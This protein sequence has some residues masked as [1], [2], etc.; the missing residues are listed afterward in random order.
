MRIRVPILLA[1]AAIAAAAF[2]QIEGSDRGVVPVASTSSYEVNGVT[3]DVAAKTPDEARYGG[4]RSAQR[5]AW[6][7]L[8]KR[9]GG[10]GGAVGDATLDQLVSG[11]VVEH[12]QIGPTRYIA[13]LGVLFNRAR[14]AALLGIVDQAA[15]SAPMLVIPIE[16]SG[17]VAQA[18]ERRTEWQAAW[19]RYRTGNS[20]IDYV[21]VAGT[22]P[23]SLLL[24]YGQ[25]QRRG[26]TWWRRLLDQY[27]ASDI[28]VPSVRLT[29]Q[30][31][32]GPVIGVFQ[33]R[34]GPDG[35]LLDSFTLRVNSSDGIPQ[36]L[37]AGVKR[38]DELYGRA[39]SAGALSTDPALRPPPQP[40]PVPTDEVGDL[41]EESDTVEET[42]TPTLAGQGVAVT[43]QYDSPTA[44][45][46]A[47]TESSLRGV[48]GVRSASTTSLALGGVSLMRVAFDGDPAALRA[49]LE[50]R[51]F[52]V[53]GSGTTLRIRRA[54]QLLPPDIPPDSAPSE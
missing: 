31:P 16:H 25:T 47:N 4:W 32:G 20:A 41:I 13:R 1:G 2:A 11:I 3:V 44:S 40:A 14:T 15:R 34:H 19:A 52:Q 24:N 9:L 39:L 27:G 22:G 54:P 7:Q 30:W 33:A 43:I 29:R 35:D 8:S 5:K 12:E 36:L 45:S 10:G 26:R 53:I 23:D 17:G 50:A 48:A 49:A 21:R 51:G 6:V 38:M 18:M 46:V 37:D 42:S 28:L